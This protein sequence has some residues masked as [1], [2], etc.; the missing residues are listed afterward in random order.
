A[1]GTALAGGGTGGG[2]FVVAGGSPVYVSDFSHVPGIAQR[3]TVDQA[4]IDRAGTGGAYNHLR[5][6]PADG[7]ALAGG[8]T[9]GGIFVVAG[10]SPVY[11]SD[12]SHVPGIAPRVTVDQSAI[13]NA[14][15]G[16]FYNHLRAVPADGTFLNDGTSGQVYR[17]AGGAPIAVTNWN[18]VGGFQPY[19]T[20]DGT[21]IGNAGSATFYRHL[22]QTPAD[23]TVLRGWG[24]G[25][26]YAV[27]GGH[28]A[29]TATGTPNT[30]VDQVAIDRA[31]TGGVYNHLN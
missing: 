5:A 16:A 18:N 29:A 25:N 4:A 7:T 13:D 27:T 12:F 15:S 22:R 30:D 8:G 20:V 1:D 17:V 9:G 2:I 23:G 10:G 31:G 14:G 3:V 21:A 6:V 26:L 28:A 24:T 11:V 19:T